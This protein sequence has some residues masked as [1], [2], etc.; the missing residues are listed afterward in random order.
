MD[1]LRQLRPSIV[2]VTPMHLDVVTLCCGRDPRVRVCVRKGPQSQGMF[3]GGT[4]ESGYVSGREPKVR[5]CIRER[6]QSQGMY[7]GETPESGYVSGREP[8]VRVCIRERPQSQG[9]YQGETPESGYVSERD[10]RVRVCVMAYSHCQI[11]T[12]IPVLCRNF[13]LVQIQTLIP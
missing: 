10:P 7:Q 6:P 1:R 8:K 12:R 3:Q 11:W 4:P 2:M 9:M 5:V 13:T